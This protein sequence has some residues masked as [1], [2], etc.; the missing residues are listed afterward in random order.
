MCLGF[1]PDFRRHEHRIEVG[2]KVEATELVEMDQGTGVGDDDPGHR[3]EGPERHAATSDPAPVQDVGTDPTLAIPSRTFDRVRGNRCTLRGRAILDGYVPSRGP[4]LA[5]PVPSGSELRF[6]S[7][8][9]C[10]EVRAAPRL[11]PARHAP[12]LLA[13]G[14]AV[15]HRDGCL[16][17]SAKGGEPAL[18][19]TTAAEPLR[20][21][22]DLVRC[23][24]AALRDR[25]L[26]RLR[27]GVGQ[28]HIRTL[29][30]EDQKRSAQEHLEKL[31]LEGINSGP[32]EP[33][34]ASDWIELRQ[35]IRAT[36]TKKIGT[37]GTKD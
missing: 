7:A 25:Q 12:T 11:R 8:E 9:D 22:H 31:L 26:T 24:S 32:A 36:A 14:R 34:T 6:E 5:H 23:G 37:R 27:P 13:G 28:T 17:S 20:P 18:C 19:L 35:H 1:I 4:V 10:S 30:R 29:L 2:K 21:M 15:L 3:L 33:W 16:A